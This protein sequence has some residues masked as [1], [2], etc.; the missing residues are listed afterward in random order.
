MGTPRSSQEKAYGRTLPMR[1]IRD[2]MPQTGS[3]FYDGPHRMRQIHFAGFVPK[4]PGPLF[5]AFEE[6]Q[7]A[8]TAYNNWT[9][10]I[11]FEPGTALFI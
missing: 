4:S 10:W 3:G 11:T 9:E 6:G 8:Y 1:Q 7:G 5:A 2:D